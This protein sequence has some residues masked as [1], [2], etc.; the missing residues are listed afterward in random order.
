MQN[1]TARAMQRM[2][3]FLGLALSLAGC[4]FPLKPLVEPTTPNTVPP[5]TAILAEARANAKACESPAHARRTPKTSFRY[6]C[7]C[8]AGWPA[9]DLPSTRTAGE[10]SKDQKDRLIAK[11]YSIQPIDDIDAACQAHDVCWTFHGGPRAECNEQFRKAM[12]HMFET[13]L[14]A[15][16]TF[17]IS[18]DDRCRWLAADLGTAN[19]FF[20]ES[21]Y[22]EGKGDPSLSLG[23]FLAFPSLL[24][25]LP[26]I[27]WG[28]VV[29]I[30][31]AP[32]ERCVVSKF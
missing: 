2:A 27:A 15:P 5:D 31:P 19:D 14:R 17:T 21:Q 4:T 30:Y 10:S 29:N 25:L 12:D 8:G 3:L 6:G 20:M 11:Y 7:F 22:A 24:L 16:S 26:S 18:L 32:N 1:A 28:S 9:L 13:F 23:R